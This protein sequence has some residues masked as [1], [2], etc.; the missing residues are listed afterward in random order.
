MRNLIS[1]L[2]GL[3][4]SAVL[5]YLADGG[6]AG[7]VFF[8]FFLGM[9]ITASIMWRRPARRFV[10]RRIHREG[11]RAI[12]RPRPEKPAT[13]PDR[14][15][16]EDDEDDRR[17]CEHPPKKRSASPPPTTGVSA[18]VVSALVNFGMDKKR[19][20]ATV[21]AVSTPGADFETLMRKALVQ[22]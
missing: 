3:V 9:L 6:T 22:K 13:D 1:F 20:R 15:L 10:R 8:G 2:A 17:T 4:V 18:D 11:P 21:E 5:M 14:G 12:N 19:A 16:W 7:Y